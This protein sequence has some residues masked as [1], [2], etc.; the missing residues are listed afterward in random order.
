MNGETVVER[1]ERKFVVVSPPTYRRLQAVANRV[2]LREQKR[3]TM[4][5][6]IKALLDATEDA[7]E[8]EDERERPVEMAPAPTQ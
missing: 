7:T 6:G 8:T 4:E 3:A 5:L 1:R 2:A